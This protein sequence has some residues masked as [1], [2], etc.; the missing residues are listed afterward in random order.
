[1]PAPSMSSSTKLASEFRV[2]GEQH[3]KASVEPKPV[4]DI[5]A[6]PSPDAV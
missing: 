5:G 3:L 1:M 2:G 6:D 4:D